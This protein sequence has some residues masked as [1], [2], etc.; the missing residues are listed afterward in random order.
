M[1]GNPFFISPTLNSIAR[2]VRTKWKLHS[3]NV[4]GFKKLET[5]RRKLVQTKLLDLERLENA[6]Q[7]FLI[8]HTRRCTPLHTCREGASSLRTLSKAAG[9][10]IISG[11]YRSKKDVPPEELYLCEAALASS[12]FAI[13][14]PT[15]VSPKPGIAKVDN[16]KERYIYVVPY[17]VVASEARWATPMY[18]LFKEDQYPKSMGC[19]FSTFQGDY[20]RLRTHF[21]KP[22]SCDWKGFDWSCTREEINAAYDIIKIMCPPQNKYDS[23]IFEGLRDYHL[24]ATL[25]YGDYQTTDM[26]VLSGMALTH[27]ID[28]IIAKLRVLYIYQKQVKSIHYGDDTILDDPDIDT[29]MKEVA[30]T[31]WQI[32]EEACCYGIEWLGLKFDSGWE[33][34]DFE[35]RLAKLCLPLRPDRTTKDVVERIQSHLFCSGNR[36]YSALMRVILDECNVSQIEPR[37]F[38][39]AAWAIDDPKISFDGLGWRDIED[40]LKKFL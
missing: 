30:H 22:W 38:D 17:G 19:G 23:R 31:P 13:L 36:R 10:T 26:G 9:C 4:E 27:I 8:E 25:R 40:R 3:G 2:D 11:V 34:V 33:V 18:L 1:D 29:L 32:K 20:L 24:N 15:K 14:P 7:L 6:K 28:T 37:W 5:S 16:P 39:L 21:K 12:D 35:K